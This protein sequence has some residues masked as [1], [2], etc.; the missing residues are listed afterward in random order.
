[1]KVGTANVRELYFEH[2]DLIRINGVPTFAALHNMFLQLK[3]N[4]VSVTCMLS[5]GTC[6]HIG[7]ILSPVTYA[8]V[9]PMNPFI[10]LVPL[11]PLNITNDATQY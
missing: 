11:G 10:I 5:K 8:T 1:M 3:A 2:Q 9:D 6:G 4:A 7:T